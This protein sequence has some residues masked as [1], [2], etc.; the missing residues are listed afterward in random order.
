MLQQF[1]PSKVGVETH[2]FVHFHA[3][4]GTV[5]VVLVV[6]VLTTKAQSEVENRSDMSGYGLGQSLY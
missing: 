1:F 4:I 2:M 3:C 6:S 5:L